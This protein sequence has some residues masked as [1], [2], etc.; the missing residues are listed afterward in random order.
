M[1]LIRY[2]PSPISTL[3]EEL[4][5]LMSGGLNWSGREL[6]G[7]IYPKVDITESSEG[8]AIKADLPGMT[9]DE[10]RVNVEE[11]VLTLS[12]EKRREIEK[13]DR[14]DYYHFE[15]SYGAFSRSFTLPTHVDSTHIEARYVNGV[16][17]IN[18]KK[19]EE[20]KPKAIEIKVE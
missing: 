15:R 1:S 9:K 12:G 20:S 4:D 16:L 11:G 17:E 6:A 3:F 18:L 14:Q 2:E 13:S 19:T 10:I 7:T 8:Y 5:T